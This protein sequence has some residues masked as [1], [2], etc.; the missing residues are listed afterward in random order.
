MNPPTVPN[1]SS[2]SSGSI[3]STQANLILVS[4]RQRGNSLLK[5]VR[6][7]KWEY[8]H[9]DSIPADYA[10]NSTCALFLSVKYHTL[11]SSYIEQRMKSIGTHNYRLRVLITLVDD[12][13]STKA[14]S[15]L[16]R[17]C[18]MND[19]ILILGWSDIEC[20]R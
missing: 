20:A 6:N 14:V 3:V 17:I 8:V 4:E 15:D 5:H 10:M 2:S 11:H 9:R 19:F 7:V 13:N 12:E 18:F 16:N 1:S